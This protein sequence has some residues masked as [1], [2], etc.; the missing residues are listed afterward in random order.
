[1]GVDFP[2]IILWSYQTIQPGSQAITATVPG[3]AEAN[4]QHARCEN[5]ECLYCESL[6]STEYEGIDP[7]VIQKRRRPALAIAHMHSTKRSTKE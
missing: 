1:M 5:C 3:I 7:E 4:L 2:R 6:G